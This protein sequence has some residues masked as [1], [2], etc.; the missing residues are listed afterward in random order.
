MRGNPLAELAKRLPADARVL[1]VGCGNFQRI[2][3][4]LALKRRDI[5]LT[6][7]ILSFSPSLIPTVEL[8]ACSMRE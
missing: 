8:I 6:S 1:D 3:R 2:F 7:L 5:V 4:N